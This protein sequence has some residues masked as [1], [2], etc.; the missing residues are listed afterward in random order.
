M[1]DVFVSYKKQDRAWAEQVV[2]ALIAAGYSVWWDDDLTPRS[3]WDAEIEREIAG[4]KVVLVLWTNRS[5]AE[6]T[7]VRVEADYAKEHGKLIPV[8][9]NDCV[10]PLAF[11]LVQTADLRRWDKVD[12]DHSEWRKVLR[13]IGQFVGRAPVLPPPTIGSARTASEPKQRPQ[14]VDVAPHAPTSPATFA[15][16][17]YGVAAAPKSPPSP[18]ELRV[19]R[20][21]T[22]SHL[23]TLIGVPIGALAFLAA[24]L[25]TMGTMEADSFLSPALVFYTPLFAIPVSLA[26]WKRGRLRIL[27]CVIL[28]ASMCVAHF[29]ASEATQRALA[30][31]NI[32]YSFGPQ[33]RPLTDCDSLPA[34]YCDWIRARAP[35]AGAIG[36]AI[37]A[38]LTFIPLFLIG[39]RKIPTMVSSFAAL[40]LVGFVG[41]MGDVPG[42]RL[43]WEYALQLFFPYQVVLGICL[44]FLL[45]EHNP[46]SRFS[47]SELKAA[48]DAFER[49][50]SGENTAGAAATP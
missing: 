44:V 34:T 11:R 40:T 14:S 30:H 32:T 45:R 29:I 15:S 22:A 9:L 21:R 13:W 49:K 1:A 3:T 38:A 2:S 25:L 16:R 37:G 19:F 41:L 8:R 35:I 10:V 42:H 17:W 47:D 43:V 28:I 33:Q 24:A 20:R 23:W 7:F 31:P 4:A 26:F 46:L 5:V 27:G 36:G 50:S 48:A 39:V 6:G 12:S 18:S